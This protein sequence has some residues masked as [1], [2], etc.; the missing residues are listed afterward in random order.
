[1]YGNTFQPEFDVTSDKFDYEANEILVDLRAHIPSRKK[2][3]IENRK[4]ISLSYYSVSK[5]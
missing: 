5:K 2:T 3:A 4:L 1:M